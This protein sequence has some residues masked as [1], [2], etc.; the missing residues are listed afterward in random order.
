MNEDQKIL[1]EILGKYL[2][3]KAE[4]IRSELEGIDEAISELGKIVLGEEKTSDKPSGEAPKP[5]LEEI[6]SLK[7]TEKVSDKGSYR[8]VTKA[9]NQNNPVF[10]KLQ[11]Y[12]KQKNG[13]C[14]I[15]GQ[16]IWLF[17]NDP[18]NKIGYRK[19]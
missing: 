16:K 9:E 4:G 11:F 7:H 10:K 6:N 8:L 18:E 5:T 13:F 19:Q 12:L 15:H 2:A 1:A 14:Q 17:S 3:S